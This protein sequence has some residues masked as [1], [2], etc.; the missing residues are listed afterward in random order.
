MLADAGAL[1]QKREF[2]LDLTFEA[3]LDAGAR[4]PT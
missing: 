1:P 4:V 2:L 3:K